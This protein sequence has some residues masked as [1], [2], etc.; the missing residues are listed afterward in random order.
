MGEVYLADDKK[1]GRRVAL[2]LLPGFFTQDPQRVRRFKRE[3]QA[4]VALNHPNI[5][6]I[7]DI[8]QAEAIHFIA[9]E[10]IEGETLRQRASKTGLKL[11]ETIEIAIQVTSALVAAH[12]AGIVHRDIKPDNIML[13]A[14]GYV[15]VLDFGLAKL[16]EIPE[17]ASTDSEVATR[18][19]VQTDAGVVMGTASYMSPEQARGNEMDARTD[20]W[21]LGVV[22]YE[23]TAGRLPFEGATATEAIARIIEREPAP[24]ARYAPQLPAELERIVTKA[25]TKDREERY[26]TAKDL[27]VDL[28]RLK[29]RL[30]VES[31]I[32]RVRAPEALGAATAAGQVAAGP[33]SLPAIG[34]INANSTSSAEYVATSPRRYKLGAVIGLVMVAA[35]AVA[36]LWWYSHLRNTA[37]AIDSI[38]VLPFVNASG[39]S[40]VD[41]LSDGMTDML[42]TS[43]SQ[44]PQLSVKAHSSVFRYKGKDTSARQLGKE[45]NVQAILNGR[46]V[47][48]GNDLTL[49][50]E[51]VEVQTETALWSRDYNRSMANLVLLQGEIARDVSQNLRARLSGAEA[52]KM[53]KDYTANAEAYQLYLKGRFHVLKLTP[54]EIQQGIAYLQQAIQLDPNYALAYVG[55]SDANRSLAL[56]VEISPTEVLPKAR[57]A[58]QKAIE[59]DDALAEA[60][61]ALG[62]TMFWYDLNWYEAE[63]QYKRA[64][65]LNPNSAD[66]HVFYAHLLSNAG[67]HAEGLGEIKRARALDPYSPFLSALEGQFLLHAGKPDEALVRLRETF[68]LAPGFWLPHVFASSADIEKGMFAEAITEARRATELSGGQTI[69]IALEG[70]CLAKLGQ[71]DEARALLD[72]LLKR[73]KER[74]VPPCHIALL[75]N[76]LGERDQAIAWLE[77]GFE[78]R[79]PKVAFLKVDPKWNNLRNE[80]RFADL[81]RRLGLS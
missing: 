54:P 48:H 63:N 30:E 76:A 34:T 59:I 67:R 2:K 70:Y 37:V 56:S 47:Q 41:Y 18:A 46:V 31:E 1:M 80:P 62:A 77:R 20:I 38:A 29:Q 12:Q 10:L 69:S 28:K 26:Q 74:F 14:D 4:V 21:S 68:E 73:S 36:G 5:V 79:D 57:A 65:E 19:L 11:S 43:L 33:T 35:A 42:I 23:L 24:L 58:A 27:L 49:H 72:G 51:L 60:H 52:R 50:I 64:L 25:L 66:T 61:T 53:T 75:Y 78:Q 6:T 15:K 13:R 17:A 81:M 22:V 71:R 7:Y 32:E 8:G 39:S 16:L 44:L 55:L 9:T 3:A 40:E 45:L